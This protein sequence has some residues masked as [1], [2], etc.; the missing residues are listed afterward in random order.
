MDLKNI[1]DRASLNAEEVQLRQR[2]AQAQGKELS[3]REK[4]QSSRT[5]LSSLVGGRGNVN[6]LVSDR[7]RLQTS[8]SGFA[9]RPGETIAG[10]GNRRRVLETALVTNTLA[11][12]ELATNLDPLIAATEELSKIQSKRE[13]AR[14]VIKDFFTAGPTER[15]QQIRELQEGIRFQQTGQLGRGERGQLAFAGIQRIISGLEGQ[16]RF[17]DAERLDT[18]L[19]RALA[20]GIGRGGALG[21]GL[22]ARGET[23]EEKRAKR[24]GGAVINRRGAATDILLL[25]RQEAAIKFTRESNVAFEKRS[26]ALREALINFDR[27][28]DKLTT[29]LQTSKIE[30]TVVVPQPIPV[31]VQGGEGLATDISEKIISLL[32]ETI[33]N[34]VGGTF[35]FVR[36]PTPLN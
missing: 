6:T 32:E 22:T 28:T 17:E 29:A 16:Q 10:A 11:L 36:D 23:D 18:K 25:E 30:V 3:F 5:R 9:R 7:Q 12:Q 34:G 24:I 20:P 35:G 8:I 33:K 26:Q 1:A 2:L 19:V 14:N 27:T 4:L 13:S 31:I 15:L 21:I